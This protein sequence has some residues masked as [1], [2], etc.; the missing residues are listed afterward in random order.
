MKRSEVFEI[1]KKRILDIQNVSKKPVRVAV[2]GIEGTGKTIFT[3]NLT[4]FLLQN[5]LKA[6]HISI[7]GFHNVSAIR[8]KHGRDSAKGYYED[9]YNE[10]EFVL[11]VLKSSQLDDP[12]IILEVHDMNTD[13]ILH[14]EPI[15]IDNGTIILTDGSY[16]FKDA[17]RKHWDLKIYLQTD[18]QTAMAR[19]INRDSE[20]LGGQNKAKEKYES[21][22]HK[23]SAI[24]L[25]EYKPRE[26][27]DIM[28]DNTDLDNLLLIKE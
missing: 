14:N 18:F 12:E 5:D 3:K 26:I 4:D 19:G 7:D 21:R 1:I 23:A 28:I 25:E 9:A 16:L 24:Y 8:Y 2:N 17:Y 27:A 20:M 6:M 11:K 13:S 15:K 10:T 22:Y